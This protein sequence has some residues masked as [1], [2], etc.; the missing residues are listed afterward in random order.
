MVYHPHPETKPEHGQQAGVVELLA[1][2]LSGLLVG[3]QVEVW[4]DSAQ[5]VFLAGASAG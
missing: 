5:G 1:P 3:H 2:W 4:V